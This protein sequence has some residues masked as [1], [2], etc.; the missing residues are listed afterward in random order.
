M[1]AFD[2]TYGGIRRSQGGGGN[3]EQHGIETSASSCFGNSNDGNGCF[4]G[5]TNDGCIWSPS[6]AQSQSNSSSTTLAG[7]MRASALTTMTGGNGGIPHVS[8]EQ[9][10]Q[11]ISSWAQLQ[12]RNLLNIGSRRQPQ[13]EENSSTTSNS[14][15]FPYLP[16]TQVAAISRSKG[17]PMDDIA[18]GLNRLTFQERQQVYHDIHGTS[19]AHKQTEDPEMVASCVSQLQ[20]ILLSY[21]NGNQEGAGR[22]TIISMEEQSL[23]FGLK[24]AMNQNLEYVMDKSFLISFLR[25]DEWDVQLASK[26]MIKFFKE[27]LTLFGADKLTKDITID[28]D[29]DQDDLNALESGGMQY[30][31]LQDR[32][33]R[34]MTIN[35][36]ALEAVTTHQSLVSCYYLF[37]IVLRY[38]S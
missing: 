7:R 15:I 14:N 32:S 29:L 33:G 17:D 16:A 31:P 6:F 9:Q 27:K 37:S 8:S 38:F 26:R 23:L 3:Q 13:H 5:G 24:Q 22:T 4:T 30:I 11:A 28:D 21:V 18:A 12:L 34:H 2:L 1:S 10:Q 20:T 25:A 35:V 19:D 36:P